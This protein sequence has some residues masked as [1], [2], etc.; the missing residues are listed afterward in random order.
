LELAKDA[1]FEA[2]KAD[3]MSLVVKSSGNKYKIIYMDCSRHLAYRN[4]RK[5]GEVERERVTLS[6]RCGCKVRISIR[7]LSLNKS[8]YIISVF[9]F[10]HNHPMAGSADVFPEN[11][12]LNESQII[13]FRNLISSNLSNKQ[14]S[15]VMKN[16]FPLISMSIQDVDNLKNSIKNEILGE[17]TELENL[18]ECIRKLHWKT[19]VRKTE[20]NIITGFLFIPP[21]SELLV[22]LFGII[23]IIDAT[24]KTN[25]CEYPLV[26]GI[27]IT[28][29]WRS[30]NGFYC[31]LSSET[32][33]DYKWMM[34]SIK[35]LLGPSF[36][37]LVFSTDREMALINAIKTE[38]PS[39]TLILCICFF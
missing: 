16:T 39:S 30:F 37:P 7:P 23:M 19:E 24:Y 27:G 38:Y 13:L 31:F 32:E 20:S 1:A 17:K 4:T 35:N 8:K 28:N 15:I 3:N 26:Q 18:I 29:T 33:E 25:N 21:S 6:R 14:I 36:N 11:R 34:G 2:A 22:T 9:N 5:K 12:K 10:I